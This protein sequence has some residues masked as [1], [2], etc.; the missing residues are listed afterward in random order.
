MKPLLQLRYLVLF[1]HQL[2]SNKRLP[3]SHFTVFCKPKFAILLNLPQTCSKIARVVYP[4]KANGVFFNMCSSYVNKSNKVAYW[5]TDTVTNLVLRNDNHKHPSSA[6]GMAMI[7]SFSVQL[8]IVTLFVI[9]SR[10]FHA[11]FLAIS[12]ICMQRGSAR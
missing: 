9:T 3:F 2:R 10:R 6:N 8:I 1:N 5:A 4:C 11:I 7:K 12:L